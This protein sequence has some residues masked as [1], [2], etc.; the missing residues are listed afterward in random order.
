MSE[1]EAHGEGEG[2]QPNHFDIVK[3]LHCKSVNKMIYDVGYY[4]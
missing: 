2:A 3:G 1:S 4:H